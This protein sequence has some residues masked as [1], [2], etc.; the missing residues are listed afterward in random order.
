MSQNKISCPYCSEQIL[1]S[2]KKCK[3]CG[4]FIDKDVRNEDV[5]DGVVKTLGSIVW[6]IIKII[7]WINVI[8][9][10]AIALFGLFE[11]L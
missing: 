9:F 4:E 1:A 3:H 11:M 8:I 7:I 10:G 5:A 6:K 2:A